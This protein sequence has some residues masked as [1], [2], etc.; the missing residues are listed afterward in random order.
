MQVLEKLNIKLIEKS[1]DTKFSVIILNE[2]RSTNSFGGEI[3][4]RN[5]AD[6]VAFACQGLPI[7]VVEYDR[8][9]SILNIAKT[10]VDDTG[11]YTIFLLSST[12]LLESMVIANIVEYCKYKDINICKLPVGYV[13][14]NKYIITSDNIVAD[15]FY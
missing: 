3:L 7:R 2:T 5:L 8:K 12:P 9:D 14:K 13:V 4:G 1:V 10:L 11:D 15:S 6:W